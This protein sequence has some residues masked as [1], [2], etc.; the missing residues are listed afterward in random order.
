MGRRTVTRLMDLSD[1]T[2]MVNKRD[3]FCQDL[4]GRTCNSPRG[5]LPNTE[6]ELLHSKRQW[7]T[8]GEE[9]R[10]DRGKKR[11][12][13][14]PIGLLPPKAQARVWHQCEVEA[15]STRGPSVKES[16]GFCQKPILGKVG[17]QLGRAIPNYFSRRNRCILFRGL[18]WKNCASPLECK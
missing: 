12:S 17:T 9:P 10:S 2:V 4:W 13:S 16:C 1:Y 6:N 8:T 15:I 3:N 14:N 11:K 18:R 7:W 5:K